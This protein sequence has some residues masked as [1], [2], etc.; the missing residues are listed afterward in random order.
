MSSLASEGKIASGEVEFS[1]G[2][3]P[4]RPLAKTFGERVIAVGD[5][6]GQV[7]PTTG[8]GIYY[9]LLC[10]DMA[11]STLHRALE[12]NGL[13]ARG[14]AGYE[15]RW[16][17]KLGRELRIGYWARKLYERLSDGQVDRVFDI[18]TSN[19]IDEA[20]LKAEGLSFDW[21]G[22]VMLRLLRER[23]VSKVMGVMRVPL[24][25]GGGG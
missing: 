5:V 10:A 11:A 3:I 24:R 15:R 6:A 12:S 18:I 4:L 2:G 23:A 8:G 7:K 20:L 19:G 9:G 1:Y 22:E 16:K 21:H 25:F 13:S 14:L 17:G